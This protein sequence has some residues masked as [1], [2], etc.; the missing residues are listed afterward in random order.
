MIQVLSDALETLLLLLQ[1]LQLGQPLPALQALFILLYPKG[2]E[3]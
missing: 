1:T 3:Q 2:E